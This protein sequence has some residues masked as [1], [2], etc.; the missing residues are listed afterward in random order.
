MR[1]IIPRILLLT[2]TLLWM[3]LIFGFSS[4]T[5]EESGGLSAL[6][7]EPVTELI[8]EMDDDMTPAEEEALYW[9]VDGAVRTAAHFGEYMVLGALLCLT[10]R[11]FGLMRKWLPWLIGAAY[12]VTD[13][14]H[15]SFAPGRVCDP[16]DMM[17]DALG[18]FCGVGAVCL[19]IDIW[20]KK[21]VHHS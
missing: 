8:A 9:R 17:I 1:K 15:Q 3:A 5:G 7:A 18:V 14:V 2:A 16:L 13:E 6:I 12:A 20:R 4:Q 10:L 19:M 11:S 21:H